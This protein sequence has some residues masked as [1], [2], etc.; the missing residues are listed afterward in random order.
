MEC[1]MPPEFQHIL[2]DWHVPCILKKEMFYPYN[3]WNGS[4]LEESILHVLMTSQS[5]LGSENLGTELETRLVLATGR[6]RASLSRCGCLCGSKG[7]GSDSREATQLPVGASAH[8]GW[9]M[10]SSWLWS[11]GTGW[12]CYK[13]SLES[14]GFMHQGV[15]SSTALTIIFQALCHHSTVTHCVLEMQRWK[16][17]KKQRHEDYLIET[18]L[19]A[20]SVW[21]TSAACYITK[22][23][24]VRLKE[25]SYDLS[26]LR[27]FHLTDF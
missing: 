7:G 21:S 24:F 27:Q 3:R 2:D 4:C 22:C 6:H 8:R 14:H 18:T 23:T 13:H 15:N 26:N 25:C 9:G 17:L 11:S 1:W 19:K 12:G 20:F 5:E 16:K 10:L